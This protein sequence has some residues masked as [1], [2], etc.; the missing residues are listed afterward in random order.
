MMLGAAQQLGCMAG[1]LLRGKL[2]Q[3]AKGYADAHACSCRPRSVG[4]FSWLVLQL[5]MGE[6]KWAL[7][8]VEWTVPQS[9]SCR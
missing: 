2:M 6:G 3:G 5:D 4:M 1:V 7:Q 8:L 9:E